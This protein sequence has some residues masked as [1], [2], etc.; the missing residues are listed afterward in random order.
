MGRN[1]GVAATLRHAELGSASYFLR[2][3]GSKILKQLCSARLRLQD[4]GGVRDDGLG[5]GMTGRA[6]PSSR[7]CGFV[8]DTLAQLLALAGRRGRALWVRGHP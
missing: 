2:A 3:V 5:V 6:G 8:R 1:G 7:L 4:D